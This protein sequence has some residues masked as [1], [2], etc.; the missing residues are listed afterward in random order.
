MESDEEG[1]IDV[2]EALDPYNTTVISV[3]CNTNFSLNYQEE[4]EIFHGE[5]VELFL[6]LLPQP[7]NRQAVFGNAK[8]V[9]SVKFTNFETDL[10]D[11]YRKAHVHLI[12]SLKHT[13]QKYS[14]KKLKDRLH[15][16]LNENYTKAKNWYVH[17][18]LEKVARTNYNN[19]NARRASNAVAGNNPSNQTELQRLQDPRSLVTVEENGKN[20]QKLVASLSQLDVD[21]GNETE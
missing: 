6:R 14:V 15:A 16:W 20:I 7:R 2:T 18:V 8:L 10:G 12:I 1:G 3:T 13:V 5:M 11:K 17:I 21:S 4:L 19:K 9:K